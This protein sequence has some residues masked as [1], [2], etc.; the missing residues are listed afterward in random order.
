MLI[1]LVGEERVSKIIHLILMFA[2][3]CT[4]VLLQ[5]KIVSARVFVCIDC[6]G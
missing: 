5:I 6:S 3:F 4:F 2:L 1:V